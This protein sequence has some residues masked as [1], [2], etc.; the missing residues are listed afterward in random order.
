MS[1]AL[2]VPPG[3]MLTLAGEIVPVHP[4]GNTGA[5]EKVLATQP[6]LSRFET[7]TA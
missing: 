7:E 5:S 2:A 3:D 4:L 6:A 1:V